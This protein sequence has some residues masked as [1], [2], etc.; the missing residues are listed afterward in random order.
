MKYKSIHL[1]LV[2]ILLPFLGGLLLGYFSPLSTIQWLIACLLLFVTFLITHFRNTHPISRKANTWLMYGVLTSAGGLLMSQQRLEEQPQHFSHYSAVYAKGTI[3]RPLEEKEKS[4]KSILSIREIYADSTF[5]AQKATGLLLVYLEKDSLSKQLE[6][7]DEILFSLRYQQVEPPKNPGQFNYRK[8]L[9]HKGIF[10]Q[11]YLASDYFEPVRKHTAMHLRRISHEAG[12][13]VQAILK[14]YIP[15]DDQFALADGILLGHRA[16]IDMEL[17]NAFAYTGILHILSVSGLHVGIIYAM[18]LFL[19]RF[20]PNKNRRIEIGKFLFIT[21]FIWMFAFITGLS[22]AC[23]RAAIL[24]S[25]LNYGRLN[26]EY[27]NQL[28]ILAGAAL[29]QLLLDVNQLFDIGFQLSYLAMLGLFIFTKPIYALY[30]YPNKAIDWTWQL[31]SA[32]IAAQCFTVP[33]SIY[34]FGNF[35]TYFLLANIFAI[36]LSTLILWLGIALIPFS[37]IPPAATL[38]GWLNAKII[39]LFIAMTYFMA[40]LP[41]GKIYG[42][43]LT[44]LQLVLLLAAVLL[45]TFYVTQQKKILLPVSL[46]I[47]LLVVGVSIQYTIAQH[48]KER[49]VLYSVPKKLVIGYSQRGQQWLYCSDTIR[50]KEY[51]FHLQPAERVFRIRETHTQ[52]LQQDTTTAIGVADSNFMM[53]ANTSFYRLTKTNTRKQFS[54]PLDIDYLLLSDNCYLDTAYVRRNFHYR[55]LVIST[56][57]DSKHLRIYK[58]LLEQAN[59]PYVDL[60]EKAKEIVM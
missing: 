48:R 42:L 6:L 7:G 57:N 44:E 18:L 39:T 4:Y 3:I 9:E 28:N 58:R 34:Y 38:I 14:K 59:M 10:H 17:Y 33:L 40:D 25:L 30:Y 45:F 1:P 43:Y 19:L 47:C 22:A 36:P 60:N 50:E 24:F 8:Y 12:L 52:Y 32:S 21:L 15:G 31:W 51:S 41:L 20:I 5:K 37:F 16:D 27:V 29:L 13:W 53:V 26:K 11:Q 46:L 2:R 56:D 55:Q 35:P 49:L 54:G 23:V